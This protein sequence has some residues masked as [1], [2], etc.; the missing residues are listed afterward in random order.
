M[1]VGSRCPL[2]A[3]IGFADAAIAYYDNK[4][5]AETNGTKEMPYHRRDGFLG[6]CTLIQCQ[7]QESYHLIL[8]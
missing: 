2:S 5:F 8:S 6:R 4:H 3:R 7:V 1:S